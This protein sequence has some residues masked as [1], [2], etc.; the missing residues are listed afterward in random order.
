MAFIP[1]GRQNVDEHDIRSVVRVLRSAWL[2]QGPDITRFEKQIARFV[3]SRYGVAVA[4]GTCALHLAYLAA[5]IGPGDEIITTP[6]TFVATANAALY[7]GARPVFCDIRLDTYNIDE[8]KIESCIT[9]RT[10]AIVPVHFSGHPCE[11]NTILRIAKKHHLLVIEDAAHALG[12]EYHGRKIGSFRTAMAEFSFHPVKTITTAEGGLITT[13]EKK[14]YEKLALLRTHGVTKDAAGKNIMTEL[15]YNYRITDLQAALGTSQLRKVREFAVKRRQV[16]SW[17]QK[18]LGSFSEIIL[19]QELPHITSSWH[20]YVIRT[21]K[22]RDRDPLFSALK[23]KRIGVN[24]H[25][26]LVYHHPYYRKLG[27]G[28]KKLPN[29]ELYA[30]TCMTLPLHTLMA[31]SQVRY[32]ANAIKAYYQR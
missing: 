5:G 7:V 26:P 19:P 27:Y 28:K 24:F 20:L 3:H 12:A 13:H 1:Y 9:K 18:E 14:Y 25:Y 2:T 30:R 10:K 4:N 8:K 16:V 11:M 22:P 32:I 17:Y 31:P 21:R 6:N 29:A 23:K 15:G